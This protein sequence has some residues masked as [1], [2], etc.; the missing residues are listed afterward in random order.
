M[1][2]E[3]NREI[4]IFVVTYLMGLNYQQKA[5]DFRMLFLTRILR[6]FSYGML[7]IVFFNNLFYKGINPQ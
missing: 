3:S 6:M 1:N 7:A 4:N 5:R 2:K